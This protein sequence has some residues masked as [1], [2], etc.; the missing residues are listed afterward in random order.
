MYNKFSSGS[1]VGLA[2]RHDVFPD[3]QLAK[4]VIPSIP[5]HRSI[6]RTSSIFIE[7]LSQ[8]YPKLITISYEVFI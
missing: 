7:T 6:K 1:P 5:I 8:K 3:P 4:L 2:A